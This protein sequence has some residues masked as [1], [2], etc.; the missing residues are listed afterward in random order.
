[1]A[2]QTP[3][4]KVFVNER[5]FGDFRTSLLKSVVGII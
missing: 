3:T 5:L 2:M 1:M 4:A